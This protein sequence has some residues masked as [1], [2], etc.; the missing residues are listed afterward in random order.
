MESLLFVLLL[1][2]SAGN[3]VRLNLPVTLLR[4]LT[5][6][7]GEKVLQSL[8]Q[9]GQLDG[10]DFGEILRKAASGVRGQILSRQR[11]DGVALQGFL[12]VGA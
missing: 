1:K 11:D 2:D 5:E 9:P 10:L 3:Q 4:L 7:G 6:T 8:A 12:E